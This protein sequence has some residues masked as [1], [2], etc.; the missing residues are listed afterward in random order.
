MRHRKHITLIIILALCMLSGL[1]A[2]TPYFI[3]HKVIKGKRGY[4]SQ[5]I[6]QDGQGFIWIGTSE[7]LILYDGV[8]YMLYTREDGMA[9]NSVTAI[10]QDTLGRIWIGHENGRITHYQYGDLSVFMP[11]EGLGNIPIT[12]LLSDRQGRIW[13]STEGEGVYYYSGNRLYNL[14]SD[15]GLADDYSYTLAMAPGDEIWIGTDFGISIFNASTKSFGQISMRDGIPDNIIRKIVPGPEGSF[16]VGTDDKGVFSIDIGDKQFELIDNW[17]F[18]SINDLIYDGRDIWVSTA[19]SGVVQVIPG[20]GG[21]VRYNLITRKQGLMSDRTQSI[22]MDREKNLWIGTQ[23][24]VTQSVTSIFDFLDD[25]H[26]LPF[27]MIYDFLI[28]ENGFYWICSENGLYKVTE[29][30]GGGFEVQKLFRGTAIENYNFISLFEDHKN[31]IWAGTYD[32]GVFRIN[33]ATLSFRQYTTASGLCDNNVISIAARDQHIL[34]STLGG[35]ASLCDISREPFQ[36]TN[37]TKVYPE[38]N[39]YI[40]STLVDSRERIWIAQAS[41]RLGYISEDSLFTF[42]HE[43]SLFISTSYSFVEDAKDNIWF[44]T[45]GNGL[46]CYDGERFINYNENTGLASQ[47]ILSMENDHYGNLVIVTDQGIDIFDPESKLFYRFGD[48][49]GVSYREPQ[50]NSIF[51]HRNG[52]I[53]IGTGNGLIRYK[54][55]VLFSDTIHP[56][57]HI[58]SKEMLLAEIEPGRWKFS[59]KQNHFSFRYTALWYQ[60]P[61]RI[62]YRSIL[63][64]YDLE[65]SSA[66]TTRDRTY[67]KLPAGDYKF[68]VEA[69]LDGHVWIG[70]EQANYSFTIRPPFWRTAWFISASILASLL[71]ILAI[72]RIRLATLRRQ[73]EEL[74]REVE[75]ATEEIRNK[76]AVLESQ[77]NEI[78]NQRDLVMEQRDQIVRQQEELQSSIRYAHRIQTAVRTPMPI[79]EKLLPDSFILDKPRDIVS[80]DFYWVAEKNNQVYIAVSDC[81]GHGV[82]GAFMSM[83]GVAGFNEILSTEDCGRRSDT[84]LNLLREHVKKAL[85]HTGE[86]GDPVDGMDVAMCILDM[87]HMKVTFTG[88]YNPLYLIRDGELNEFKGDKMPIGWYTRDQ[89]PFSQI[90]IEVREGDCLYMFSD[91]YA[92]QFGGKLG[93]KFMSKNFKQLLLDI[94]PRAMKDQHQFL[95]ETIEE[96]KAGREQVDD[97]MVMGIRL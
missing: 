89:Q 77:K 74:Q 72:F 15:D 60:D 24:E 47:D 40:F 58:S 63:E 20:E 6:F 61:D 8:D 34:F 95:E 9:G 55:E 73:K 88:A 59:H 30:Q 97:I 81:T 86:E 41:D 26:G 43:D 25:R 21:T 78:Q 76:N 70:S 33:P 5:V 22:F 27:N 83:L 32:H 19:R 2:Q 65:W 82:P 93:K 57:I 37:L 17:K 68:R 4:Q 11:E 16:L 90:E 80:G 1:L 79:V 49:Y 87:E 62:R 13:F 66:T 91:G 29:S 75:K 31:Y 45:E 84:F 94:H 39:N 48:N 69:S 38:L 52:E 14:N 36:F 35:G 51:R 54:P 71:T 44:S 50:L 42:G 12:D 18:G 28:D 64:G 23:D 92:D 46:Y 10:C 85:H 53:W 7:G 56:L 3:H 96:W 67:S